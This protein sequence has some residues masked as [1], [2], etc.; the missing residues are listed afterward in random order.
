MLNSADAIMDAQ[1]SPIVP[2]QSADS[3]VV[4]GMKEILQKYTLELP[5]LGSIVTGEIISTGKSAVMID[6][7]PLGTGMV[8][9]GEFYD[10][11]TLQKALKPGQNVSSILLGYEDEDGLGYRELSLKRAQM[12][13]AWD[14]IK[15][16]KESGEVTSVPIVNINKGGLIVEINGIQGFLPL[17]QL[18]PTHYP[19]VERGD[20][21]KIV[22]ALQKYR[23]Q[24]FEVK[25][26]DFSET[27]NR[28]IVSEKAIS[29][30]QLR[31]ELS[32]YHVGDIVEG[33][34]TDVTDFGAFVWLN[35]T[36]SPATDE[37]PKAGTKPAATKPTLQNRIEGLF[38]IPE[39]D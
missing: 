9:P 25:I 30:A 31:E 7:G 8:Y 14:D 12:T 11:T 32:K 24:Q 10:N 21:T 3:P 22:Q 29:D 37:V 34:I 39:I 4:F 6:L 16:K 18:S 38:H 1:A 36:E 27:E 13:T 19:K 28:L 20:T 33:V 5:K 23:G 2:P 26:I 17:S 15:N 35:A